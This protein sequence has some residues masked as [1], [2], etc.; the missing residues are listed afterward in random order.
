M[1]KPIAA[2]LVAALLLAL[3]L[4]AWSWRPWRAE[5]AV[6]VPDGP[7]VSSGPRDR[8]VIW[9]VGDGADGGGAARDLVARMRRGRLDR[10][11]YLGDVYATGPL[12][13][14]RPDGT[15]A[16]WRENYATVYGALAGRTAPT[17]GNHGWRLRGEGYL[18]YWTRVYGRP[19]PS[20]YD[21]A[22]AGWQVLSLNSQAPHAAHSAQL[23]WL[24]ERVRA[25][26]TCRLA[27]WHRPRF[28]AGPHGDAP[29]LEPLWG[30]LRGRGAIVVSGHDHNMQRLRPVDGLV[31]YVSGAGG[32]GL[33][34][35]SDDARLA[36]GNDE[37]YG[38]LRI[39]LRPGRARLSFVTTAGRVLDTSEVRCRR[40]G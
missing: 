12:A 17:P 33:Y 14:L 38:A 31:Q 27:F 10:L 1:A 9:A 3:A 21:F 37:A 26:G 2:V 30:A 6:R 20:F 11:L 39:E 18:P 36:F 32:H 29:D 4:V 19:V 34:G 8:A 40:A 35:F 23:R 15:A 24:R 7:F 28:S 5:R 22:V 25:P 13:A 16:D